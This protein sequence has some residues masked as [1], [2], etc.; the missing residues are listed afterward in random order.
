MTRDEIMQ[1]ARQDIDYWMNH[2][3]RLSLADM[4]I[5]KRVVIERYLGLI[6]VEREACAQLCIQMGTEPMEWQPSKLGIRP[7]HWDVAQA[8]RA[9]GQK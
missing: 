5:L 6:A 2:Y 4:S 1:M 3:D 9:R 8:I 7:E